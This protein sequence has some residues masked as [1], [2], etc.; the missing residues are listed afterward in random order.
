MVN[1]W[2]ASRPKRKL[3]SVPEVLAVI[4]AISLDQEWEGQRS[5]HLSF[6][7]QLEVAGIKRVGERRDQSGSGARTY[8]AWLK[9]LGLLFKQESSGQL[10]LT[11]A[12][13]S[14]M[15]GEHTVEVIRNQVLKYQFPSAY[16]TGK[17]VDVSRRFKI[18]PFIFLLRLLTDPRI[19][20]L[21]NDEIAKIII[22]EAENESD[23]CYEYIVSRIL[24]F[25]SYGDKIL[26]PDFFEKYIAGRI[27]PT[28]PFRKL[29]DTAN[30]F[31]NWLEYTQ[32]IWRGPEQKIQILPGKEK[33]ARDIVQN[34]GP[35]IDRVEDEEFFQRK[36][37]LDP[38]H[39]KDTRNL[40]KTKTITPKII[41]ANQIQQ[42]FIAAS[43]KKPIAKITSQIIEEISQATGYDQHLV[44]ETLLQIYPRGAIGA[45]LPEYFDMAFSGREEAAAFEKA[46]VDLFQDVFGYEA[47][48]VGPIGLTPD[49]LLLSDDYGYQAIIDNKA[50]AKYTI[51]NDH[52]NRMVH[53]YIGKLS[54]YSKAPHDLAFFSYIAGGFGSTFSSQVQKIYQETGIRGSG[55]NVSNMIK[56]IED[57]QAK[58]YT[59]ATLRDLFTLNRE[60]DLTD[61]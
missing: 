2:W 21:T 28:C 59:H 24:D 43:I 44:E 34:V 58:G 56:L 9:S 26:A 8:I 49:V 4:S 7:D 23:K 14:I 6:E 32:L 27:D 45:F 17:R 13:E 41:R 3:N 35:F 18:R 40:T 16:S 46:T 37:G 10:K 30:T 61:L 15:R 57:Y 1:F 50:Y 33:A 48:H 60:I 42:A 5:R 54:R 52:H 22:V 20:Y 51:S 36:Y 29:T 53:N 47:R 19:E 11:L 55:I 12:G 39:I 31:I 25:R 38:Y